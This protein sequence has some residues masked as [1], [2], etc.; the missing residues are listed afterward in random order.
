[1]TSFTNSS[2]MSS[3]G[4][5]VVAVVVVDCSA[6][7]S[8]A[9]LRVRVWLLDATVVLFILCDSLTTSLLLLLSSSCSSCCCSCWWLLSSTLAFARFV[10]DSS[11]A[12]SL[13]FDSR[14]CRDRFVVA[15]A[16][17]DFGVFAPTAVAPLEE[18]FAVVRRRVFID[19]AEGVEAESSV[20]VRLARLLAAVVV[21]VVPAVAVA[22]F[23]CAVRL[24]RNVGISPDKKKKKKFRTR[25]Q[26]I[27]THRLYCLFIFVFKKTL[28]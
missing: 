27:R 21:V 23:V 5:V 12:S 20:T 10:N 6:S 8:S 13:S 24:F 15:A 16:A 25:L 26:S 4:C 17:V 22:L 28:P 7:S 19:V 9:A 14:R 11:P 2:T 18:D 1:M 3:F